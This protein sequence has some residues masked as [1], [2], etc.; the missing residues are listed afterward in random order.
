MRARAEEEK[1]REK[2]KALLQKIK[3][4]QQEIDYKRK[5]QRNSKDFKSFK[6]DLMRQ[7]SHKIDEEFS[8]VKQEPE[9]SQP[10]S[11][12]DYAIKSV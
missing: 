4:H 2:D 5:S 6:K 11:I 8:A 12:A 7:I 10:L 9:I 3:V 1:E